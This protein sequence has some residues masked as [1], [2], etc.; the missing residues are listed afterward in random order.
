MRYTYDR[1][2][3]SDNREPVDYVD[4][5]IGTLSYKTWSTSPAV[6]LPHGMIE[7]DTYT[8]PGIGDKYLADKIYGFTTG[9]FALMPTVGKPALSPAENASEYDHD[10][11][12]ATPYLYAVLLEDSGIE[13]AYTA[14]ERAAYF[15]FAFPETETGNVVVYLAGDAEAAF[16]NDGSLTGSQTFFRTKTYFHIEF[17]QAPGTTQVTAL[18][19]EAGAGR[20][21]RRLRPS[22]A[23]I[24]SFGVAGGKEVEVRAGISF[25]SADQARRNLHSEITGWDFELTKRQA[26][27]SWNT[28]LQRI[29]VE[30][31]TEDQKTSFYTAMYRDLQRMKNITED[32]KYYSGFDGEVHDAGDQDF[33]NVDQPWDTYRCA[34]PLQFILE[35]ERVNDMLQSYTRMAEQL[36]W[37]PITPHISGERATMVGRHITA[38]ITDGYNKGFRGFDLETAYAGMRASAL[39]RTIL[40][41]VKGPATELDRAYD[42][43][44]YYPAL[45]TREDQ[46]VD[47]PD[48]W[49]ANVE[50][51]H[52]VRD[53]VPDHVAT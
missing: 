6:Q 35:P 22:L 32:G 46:K 44:G 47:D 20:G 51:H 7:I 31:G 49:R 5:N 3:V 11:E 2:S 38:I 28:V 13:V 48:E 23:A 40:P 36:G 1:L 8:T 42:E 50:R 39:D 30:G 52:H 26:R 17:G 18:E 27:E 15:R 14:S 21:W 24:A 4:T 10:L 45:P 9:A 25:I 19:E 43:L 53:A 33:Y 41:W 37:M 34:R 12:L 29:R 16:N